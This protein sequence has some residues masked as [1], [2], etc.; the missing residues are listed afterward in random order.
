VAT[1]TTYLIT[2]CFDWGPVVLQRLLAVAGILLLVKYYQDSSRMCLGGAFFL[3]GLALWDK[4]IFGWSLVGF[5]AAGLLTASG[6]IR[7][8]LTVK[9]L[10]VALTC[11]VAG[12][13][14]LIRYNHRYPFETFRGTVS[15]SMSGLG[16]KVTVLQSSLDG[17]GMLG[18]LTYD[19]PPGRTSPPRTALE[20][21]SVWID[22]VTG[23]P[24][25][26][27]LPY[28]LIAAV[29][30]IPLAWRS[31]ARAPMLFALIYLLVAWAQMLFGRG[32][33]GSVHHA[34]LLWPWPQFLVAVALAELSR[35]LKRFGPATLTLAATLV[36]GKAV[37]SS[38]VYLSQLIR[39]GAPGSWSDAI[40][41][42]SDYIA[43]MPPK[44][45][46]VL[47][48]GILDP[49]RAMHRGRLA[50]V[51]GAD[52][53]RKETPSQGDLRVFRE[54]IEPPD[55]VFLSFTDAYEQF[56]GVN[57]HLREMLAAVR[58]RREILGVISDSHG[59]PVYEMFRIRHLGG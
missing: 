3:F 37:L 48:W 40:Y 4:A 25:F 56:P 22:R 7:R 39:Y 30:T 51:W 8:A 33:G 16:Q 1:D 27:F 41:Q 46:V 24:R 26:G 31:E 35:H 20:R 10:A 28:C 38:N 15:W 42:L 58:A 59:R 11:L 50:L 19:E 34:A 54:M 53:L 45:I 9:N 57:A 32:V 17:S 36:C 2:T 29:L 18:Y 5:A 47:D 21:S 6:A 49:L 13:Y 52:P 43:R 23:E 12:A 14:P 55:R 44:E